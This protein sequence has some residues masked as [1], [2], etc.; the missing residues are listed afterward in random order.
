MIRKSLRFTITACSFAVAPLAL[1]GEGADRAQHYLDEV[2]SLSAH[3][4]QT[5]VDPS[6]KTMQTSEGTLQLKRP[7]RFRWSY[8]APHEQLVVADGKRL[9]LYDPELE[10]VTVK[11]LDATLGSTP[12]ML[13]SGTGRLSDAYDVVRDYEQD[14]MTWVELTPHESKGDFARV[15]LAFAGVE[16]RRMELTDSLDQTTSIDLS[17]VEHNPTLGDELFTFTPPP[18]TDVVSDSPDSGAAP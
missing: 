5:I 14:G 11:T 3:F 17:Q 9:W 8:A 7:G 12:A 15:R 16:L 13:L 1:A 2:T 6:G 18:G 4:S 10:Q